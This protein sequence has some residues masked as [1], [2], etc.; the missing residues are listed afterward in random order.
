MGPILSRNEPSDKPGTI[1]TD[2]PNT[3]RFASQQEL[4]DLF[5]NEADFAQIE[6]HVARVLCL[7]ELAQVRQLRCADSPTHGHAGGAR[8]NDARN[9]E[10]W[11]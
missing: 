11:E 3:L 7:E 8:L 9:L 4:D 10:H 6:H 1:Q 2:K 5:V